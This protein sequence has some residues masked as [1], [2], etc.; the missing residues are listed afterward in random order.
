MNIANQMYFKGHN[1]V[2]TLQKD[3]NGSSTEGDYS[4]AIIMIMRA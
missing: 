1:D 4:F 2:I 3:N